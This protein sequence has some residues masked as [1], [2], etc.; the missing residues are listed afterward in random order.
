MPQPTVPRPTLRSVG[1]VMESNIVSSSAGAEPTLVP[2]SRPQ[3]SKVPQ[4]VL[5]SSSR[6]QGQRVNLADSV[7]AGKKALDEHMLTH[8]MIV[9]N[10][11]AWKTILNNITT[12]VIGDAEA[13]CVSLFRK[14]VRTSCL[15]SELF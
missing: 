9:N 6:G 5:Q 13:I 12:S 7:L 3:L 8:N 15:L 4:Q 11:Q 2:Y 10:T 1:L 14:K